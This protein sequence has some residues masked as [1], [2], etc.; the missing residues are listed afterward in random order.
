MHWDEVKYTYYCNYNFHVKLQIYNK[1][2]LG[3]HIGTDKEY[4]VYRSAIALY[5]SHEL[6]PE[7]KARESKRD[8][9]C[10]VLIRA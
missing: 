3:K 1:T 6:R 9:L 2:I 10:L 8:V 4:R 7:G 5:I